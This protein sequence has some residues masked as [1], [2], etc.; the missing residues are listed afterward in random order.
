MVCDAKRPMA[1]CVILALALPAL[2]SCNEEQLARAEYRQKEKKR[3]KAMKDVGERAH[4]YV[5]AVRWK[6]FQKASEFFEDSAD[7]VAYLEAMTDP[8]RS[9]PVI[10]SFSIDYVVVDED[11]T[12]AEVRLTLKEVDDLTQSLTTRS[13]TLVWY[14]SDTAIPREWFLM[15]VVMMEPES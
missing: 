2:S 10:E 15:P 14:L 9:Y 5:L 12:H 7:Q 3:K 11:N 8:R 4:D 1:M 13:D 6:D